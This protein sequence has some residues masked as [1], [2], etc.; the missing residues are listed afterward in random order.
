MIL[1]SY[2]VYEPLEQNWIRTVL[3]ASGQQ[4]GGI[5]HIKE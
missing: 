3:K 5:G 2:S 1:I 4:V